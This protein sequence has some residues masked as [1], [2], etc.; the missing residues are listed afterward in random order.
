MSTPLPLLNFFNKIIV[1]PAPA[2]TKRELEEGS[3]R[4]HRAHVPTPTPMPSSSSDLAAALRK[5][6][7]RL[8]KIEERMSVHEDTLLSIGKSLEANEDTILAM[9]NDTWETFKA[10]RAKYKSIKKAVHTDIGDRLSNLEMYSLLGLKYKKLAPE[11]REE[12]MQYFAGRVPEVEEEGQNDGDGGDEDMV[13]DTEQ[14]KSATASAQKRQRSALTKKAPNQ[15]ES[16]KVSAH[17]SA[18]DPVHTSTAKPVSASPSA[19]RPAQP[20]TKQSPSAATPA[21]AQPVKQQP[22]LLPTPEAS[23]PKPAA[24]PVRAL[25]DAPDAPARET[26]SPTT[27]KVPN[28]QTATLALPTLSLPA[29]A[30][31]AD[32]PPPQAS[33][34]DRGSVLEGSS[35][36]ATGQSPA[37]APAPAL[38]DQDV[39]MSHCEVSESPY[40]DDGGSAAAQNKSA[41]AKSAQ[42]DSVALPSNAPVVVVTGSTP[43]K[44]TSASAATDASHLAVPS[45]APQR[46]SP[47]PQRRLSRTPSPQRRSP[48]T[49]KIAPAPLDGNVPQ[50]VPVVQSG[51]PIDKPLVA[52]DEGETSE[53]DMGD[54]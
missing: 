28:V 17:S 19:T 9:E 25:P 29:T 46:R 54:D 6:E 21:P 27:K 24:D 8:S 51:P 2:H 16:A 23:A 5:I 31:A 11:S 40:K 30:S 26:A 37:P 53:M 36:F 15:Q 50:S 12:W 1:A 45:P 52:Y 48:S 34:L 39:P 20:G 44:S 47:S 13:T 14:E 35:A 41:Q 10:F 43:G 3:S 4:R 18:A 7:A 49:P 33:A 38:G 32:V 42:D 22:T